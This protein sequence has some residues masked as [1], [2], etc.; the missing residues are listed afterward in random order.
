MLFCRVEK[1]RKNRFVS[2]ERFTT[3]WNISTHLK[4]RTI[5]ALEILATI[6]IYASGTLAWTLNYPA[7]KL[8]TNKMLFTP[9]FSPLTLIAKRHNNY[10]NSLRYEATYK[11]CNIRPSHQRKNITFLI[12][13]NYS[14]NLNR[15]Q[16]SHKR[17]Y[18]T[19]PILFT[20]NGNSQYS[21]SQKIVRP[22][23]S[24][25]RVTYAIS[26]SK[27]TCLRFTKY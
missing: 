27:P 3:V 24:I 5:N 1:V 14:Q 4:T 8:Y 26:I 9:A 15:Q 2:F 16:Q 22:S 17:L 18:P 7:E 21:P 11:S 20:N 6:A 13:F 19:A 23:I 10:Q 12:S 25:Q